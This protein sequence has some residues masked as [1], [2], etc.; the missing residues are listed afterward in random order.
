MSV[1]KTENENPRKIFSPADQSPSSSPALALGSSLS[2][3]KTK[4]K[5]PQ[6]AIAHRAPRA[7]PAPRS[8]A[9]VQ[10]L[11]DAWSTG[12]T[13]FG[14]MF[15]PPPPP[16]ICVVPDMGSHGRCSITRSR[17]SDFLAW[18]AHPGGRP[19]FPPKGRRGASP[20]QAAPPWPGQLAVQS[21]R[22]LAR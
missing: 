5:L 16:S 13:G 19:R 18:P 10:L 21:P 2:S 12:F 22:T 14:L 11:H 7:L 17:H 1:V 9:P 15:R 8:L 6:R 4:S 3:I 20:L